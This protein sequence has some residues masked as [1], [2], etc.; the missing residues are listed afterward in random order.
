M[1]NLI[2]HKHRVKKIRK[3]KIRKRR[4]TVQCKEIIS[5]QSEGAAGC[6]LL[7]NLS[8]RS[9]KNLRNNPEPITTSYKI[10]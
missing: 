8:Q 1:Q 2:C 9:Q 10:A 6:K 4:K 7:K 5:L 3:E